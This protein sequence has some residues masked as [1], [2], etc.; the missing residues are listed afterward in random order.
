MR[1]FRFLC[2]KFFKEVYV[3]DEKYSKQIVLNYDYIK[4]STGKFSSS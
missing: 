2:S 4:I 3:I 1:L